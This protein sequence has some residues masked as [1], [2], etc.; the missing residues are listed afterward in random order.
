[1]TTIPEF[2]EL[3]ACPLGDSCLFASNHAGSHKYTKA[4]RKAHF[5]EH[6]RGKIPATLSLAEYKQL[7]LSRA[8]FLDQDMVA[9]VD[10][11]IRKN[12]PIPAQIITASEKDRFGKF[13]VSLFGILPCGRKF[14]VYV[15]K[16]QLFVDILVTPTISK[17]LIEHTFCKKLEMDD[18]FAGIKSSKSL[19]RIRRF[20]AEPVQVLRFA[21]NTVATRRYFI[22]YILEVNKSRRDAGLKPFETSSDKQND[23]FSM[24]AAQLEVPTAGWGQMFSYKYISEEA[25]KSS[26]TNWGSTRNNTAPG[27]LYFEL[28]KLSDF[29]KL[30]AETIETMD[31]PMR[32]AL[33]DDRMLSC[34]WDTE[35]YTDVPGEVPKPN[36]AGFQITAISMMFHWYWST[37]SLLGLVVSR[38]DTAPTP[39]TIVIRARDTLEMMSAFKYIASQ[40]R[41]DLWVGF[42]CGGYDWDNFVIVAQQKHN[43]LHELLESV[44][45]TTVYKGQKI[46]S[47]LRWSFGGEKI[48]YSAEFSAYQTRVVRPD[49]AIHVD[50]MHQLNKRHPREE[51]ERG[52]SLDWYLAKYGLQSK[53][54]MPYDR[55]HSIYRRARDLEAAP[56]ACHCGKPCYVCLDVDKLLDETPSIHVVK[57]CACPGEKRQKNL[58]DMSQ[59]V[60]YAL[61]DCV[62]PVNLIVKTSIITDMKELALLGYGLMWGSFYRADGEKVNGRLTWACHKWSVAFSSL[63]IRDKSADHTL[64]VAGKKQVKDLYP[65]GKVFPPICGLH[66]DQPLSLKGKQILDANGALEI[67]RPIV[68]LDFA[69]LY[70]SLMRAFNICPSKYVETLEEATEL[71]QLGYSIY[72]TPLIEY[73]RG[74]KRGDSINSKHSGHAWFVR[75]NGVIESTDKRIVAWVKQVTYAWIEPVGKLENGETKYKTNI[76]S[77]KLVR[78][79]SPGGLA[80]A[81]NP[82]NVNFTH[83]HDIYSQIDHDA[84]PEEAKKHIEFL[85]GAAAGKLTGER[86]IFGPARFDGKMTKH[87]LVR[88]VSYLPERNGEALPGESLGVFPW[89]LHDLAAE[90]SKV[91]KQLGIIEGLE[92]EMKEKSLEVIEFNAKSC[93]CLDL[94]VEYSK[95]DGKQKALKVIMNVFYGKSG[96]QQSS[97]YNVYVAAGITTSG[98]AAITKVAECVQSGLPGYYAW[99]IQHQLGV[100][101]LESIQQDPVIDKFPGCRV[102]Y[103]DT[104]SNYVSLTNAWF[105]DMDEEYQQSTMDSQARLAWWSR[106]VSTTRTVCELFR[107]E[108]N[109]VMVAWTGTTYLSLAYEEVLYPTFLAGK[110]KYAGI[111]HVDAI[112]FHVPKNKIFIRGLDM[113]KQGFNQQVKDAGYSIV[114]EMLSHENTSTPVEITLKYFKAALMSRAGARELAKKARYKEG[115]KTAGVTDFVARMKLEHELCLDPILKPL[116]APPLNGE[117]FD[118]VI[119]NKPLEYTI[120]GAKIAQ[121]KGQRMEYLR[122]FEYMQEQGKPLQ[123]DMEHYIKKGGLIGLCSRFIG[124]LDMFE[125]TNRD[126]NLEDNE[127]FTEYDQARREK[128][129]AYLEAIV[130]EHLGVDIAAVKLQGNKYKADYRQKNSELK[131]TLAGQIGAKNAKTLTKI[132]SGPGSSLEY[133]IVRAET[134]E[135]SRRLLTER[136]LE[137]RYDVL[138]SAT[139]NKSEILAVINKYLGI[140]TSSPGIFRNR[141]DRLGRQQEVA[142]RAFNETFRDAQITIAELNENFRTSI[143]QFRESSRD[144]Q[145]IQLRLSDPISVAAFLKARE[146]LIG[147][148][149]VL[150]EERAFQGFLKRKKVAMSG[151]ND[152]AADYR[153][154]AGTNSQDPLPFDCGW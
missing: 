106:M 31:V 28:T 84:F 124:Y 101:Y 132:V 141:M 125:P 128:A 90:R 75:H 146:D 62:G 112:N 70:P 76:A 59:T 17:E 51:I 118:Y 142:I 47:L 126:Y 123:L 21:F 66:S 34:A 144:P 11:M 153:A 117:K 109:D 143:K 107:E 97:Y 27:V 45:S 80:S 119:V 85:E 87:M 23:I 30:S 104:D 14:H 44:S 94:K 6:A 58:D 4:E 131:R 50:L 13:A 69:S 36:H 137:A 121:S 40:F 135:I 2:P 145:D 61:L 54:D 39:C 48:K 57:C 83:E 138:V 93:T 15:G 63:V 24:L 122:V 56:G 79:C 65:G 154:L 8:D 1:M 10:D 9:R 130:N 18:G 81:L 29:R 86:L 41:P 71:A 46:D 129:V 68:G 91:K 43:G 103:G 78:I 49:G 72:Q 19:Y 73:E 32:Q 150:E 64:A 133:N 42:N 116:L 113:I 22:N 151:L 7:A 5:L 16:I 89:V 115:V 136:S 98:Q 110:K 95:I 152:I 147:I 140:G 25:A 100:Q 82:Q 111:A 52:K 67:G 127:E 88:A 53:Y 33:A 3:I 108:T 92:A 20:S 26:N 77:F 114:A 102:N 60:Y 149:L 12:M 99:M 120:S 55:M 38:F 35:T 134:I 105:H 96:Q 148:N 74:K 37:Q 139:K